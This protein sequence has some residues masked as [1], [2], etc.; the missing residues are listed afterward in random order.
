MSTRL[1]IRV[2]PGARA[3]GLVGFMADGTLK[4]RVTEAPED[5]RANR[6]VEALLGQVLALRRG[7]AVVRGATG[8]SKV[9]EIEGLE[10]GEVQARLE[11]ALAGNREDAE[12]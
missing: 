11:A 4:V 1:A 9:V 10:A 8:R 12:S 5:G 3:A 2:Q 7:V 6:A